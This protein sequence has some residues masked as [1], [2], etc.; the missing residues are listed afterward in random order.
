M[1]RWVELV[2]LVLKEVTVQAVTRGLIILKPFLDTGDLHKTPRFS[3]RKSS[4]IFCNLC[5]CNPPEACPG[6]K[7][8]DC[9]NGYAGR[10]CAQCEAHYYKLGNYCRGCPANITVIQAVMGVLLVIGVLVAVGFAS[11][12]TSQFGAVSIT[13]SYIQGKR[14][15]NEIHVISHCHLFGLPPEM[16]KWCS[17]HFR[18]AISCKLQS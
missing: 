7:S 9:A 1:D 3:F 4:K 11:S 8:F 14:V 5:R 10:I 17:E 18:K 15:F 2:L 16:A 12:S 13:V 6:G